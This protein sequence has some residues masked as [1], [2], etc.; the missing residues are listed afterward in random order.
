MLRQFCKNDA[1]L[2]EQI[3]ELWDNTDPQTRKRFYPPHYMDV[4]R[5][6]GIE[7]YTLQSNTEKEYNDYCNEVYRFN[8]VTRYAYI[9]NFDSSDDRISKPYNDG[10]VRCIDINADSFL[11]LENN[12][13]ALKLEIVNDNGT[14]TLRP[15]LTTSTYEE[16]HNF[17][18]EYTT[19]KATGTKY[20]ESK[21]QLGKAK[22]DAHFYGAFNNW[23]CNNHWYNGFNRT[24]NY[25]VKSE[26]QKDQDS[27]DIPSVCHAQTFKAENTGR[28][29]KVQLN[30]QGTKTAVSPC[31]VEIRTTSKNGYPT[32]KVLARAEKKFSGG[33]QNIVAFEFKN[34]AKITKGETYAIVVRSPLSH[35]ENTFRVGGWTTGCFSSESKYY[36]YGSAF[37]SEDNG[38]S[39]IKNGKTSDKKSYGSHYYDW[40]INQKPVDLAFEVTVQ[41]IVKEAIKK[42]VTSDNSKK[43]IEDGYT[44][45]SGTTDTYQKLK[46]EAY[47]TTDTYEYTYYKD[48]TYYLHLKPI[49][50]N[51]IDFVDIYDSFVKADGT[52]STSSNYWTWE[53]YNQA[54]SSWVAI[55]NSRLNFDNNVVDFTVLKLRIKCNVVGNIYSD[56][57]SSISDTSL[58]ELITSEKLIQSELDYLK[59]TT[60]HI[61]TRK[62]TKAYL[63]TQYYYPSQT[64]I[65]GAN[66]WSEIG[67]S[68]SMKGTQATVDIDVVHEKETIEH[69]KIYDL[70]ILVGADDNDLTP[71]QESLFLLLSELI[72]EFNSSVNPSSTNAVV[73]YIY[74]D[75]TSEDKAF[76]KYL[77]DLLMPIY[78]LPL[79][80]RNQITYMFDSLKLSHLPS[81]PINASE[82]SDDDI[83]L[84]SNLF[85]RASAYGFAHPLEKDISKTIDGVYVTYFTNISTN[86]ANFVDVEGF[87]INDCDYEER[88]EEK[89]KGVVLDMGEDEVF[90]TSSNKAVLSGVFTDN[91]IDYAI[92]NNGRWILF[93]SQSKMVQKLFPNRYTISNSTVSLNPS[94]NYLMNPS[95]LS[96]D[97]TVHD[98]NIMINTSSKTYEEFVDFH[99]DYDNG[100]LEFYNQMNLMSGDFRITY[101]PLWVRGLS[102]ADFPLKLDLWI[103]EF[104]VGTDNDGV[105]GIHKRVFNET[106]GEYSTTEF[107]EK[108]NINPYTKERGYD[109]WYR[110]KTTVP[111]RDNIRQLYLNGKELVEDTQYFVDYI[112]NEIVI[113]KND[114]KVGDLL[115]IH[116]TP[117]LTDDAL[118]L[119]YRLHRPRY[120]DGVPIADD[121]LNY[122]PNSLDDIYIGMN[123][124]TYRT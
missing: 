57:T 69:Y 24:K 98:F 121:D 83:L 20:V 120:K 122:E 61:E 14:T 9:F 110:F 112:S 90:G 79:V 73:E 31:I 21:E 119:A 5:S 34:K 30:I 106:S 84:D 10:S 17:D 38:K 3:Q 117:N 49:Q 75:A 43:L 81:Y 89:L 93:N 22:K 66:V 100:T 26:W 7:S 33:G 115:E 123:Y 44:L 27:Y 91:T 29:S 32:R 8:S 2:Y 46:K 12:H 23:H 18:A 116:Y 6:F 41:P 118:A 109:T 39:W 99:V 104:I 70:N 67:T 63:R 40:G 92:T 62:P 58:Q 59:Q 4:S 48:G 28:V 105:N 35:F 64:G 86:T 102:I 37:L 77:Q 60:I 1:Y 74:T 108:T 51:P 53:Y 52:E 95:S 54:T 80:Y 72:N 94:G 111:P 71:Q 42:K 87:K 124:F 50:T 107:Y 56:T 82:I 78:L 45:V 113:F 97:T 55:G 65:L 103:E 15:P 101:N 96:N 11:D 88:I 68:L 114:L 25:N 13:N 47:T 19:R 76:I 85:T 16:I 36:K